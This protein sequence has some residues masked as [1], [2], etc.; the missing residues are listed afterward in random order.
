M[1]RRLILNTFAASIATM[2]TGQASARS[3]HYLL[4]KK[5][6]AY[7]AKLEAWAQSP[8]VVAFARAGYRKSDSAL[9]TADWQS[10]TTAPEIRAMLDNEVSRK[11]SILS[12]DSSV[13]KLILLNSVGDVLGATRKPLQ[14]NLGDTLAFTEAVFSGAWAAN[15]ARIDPVT[16][17]Y[18]VTASAPILERNREIGVL[19]LQLFAD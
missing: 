19:Y 13:A 11:L 12:Q 15:R 5:V 4:E 7:Q 3:L 18:V 10:R 8:E 14:Y 1:N 17:K 6:K 2:A 16:K 9:A